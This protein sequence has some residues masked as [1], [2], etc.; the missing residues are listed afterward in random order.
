[1]SHQ[2]GLTPSFSYNMPSDKTRKGPN[3]KPS[4]RNSKHAN[5]DKYQCH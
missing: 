4:T 1:M 2:G 3:L 5:R